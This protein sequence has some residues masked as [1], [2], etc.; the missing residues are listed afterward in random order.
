MN[1]YIEVSVLVGGV[2]VKTVAYDGKRYIQSNHGSE[3]A[4]RVRN[5]S[6]D[7]RLAVISVD[8]INVI[9][10]SAAGTTTMGYILEGLSSIEIKGF[11][12]DNSTVHPFKFSSK[13]R[14]YAAKS[15]ETGGDTSNCGVI[16]VAVYSEKSFPKISFINT[17]HTP[18]QIPEEPIWRTPD[19]GRTT[20]GNPELPMHSMYSMFGKER[21]DYKCDTSCSSLETPRSFTAE[22]SAN[23]DMGTEFSQ[24]ETHSPVSEVEFIIG[25]LLDTVSIY[26]A[27][28]QALLSMGVP[29]IKETKIPKFPDAFPK[30]FCKPPK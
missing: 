4:I 22:R 12:T 11:R 27:S 8:G 30:K 18:I 5:K 13:S 23:F 10:G 29:L 26:Y 28:R 20:A 25:L 7:R 1:T 6:Y 17:L 9:D 15:E 19:F 3:Y 2:P 16:G 24:K 14:S 21:S